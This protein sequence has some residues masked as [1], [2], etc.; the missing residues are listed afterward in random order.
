MASLTSL[1]AFPDKIFLP[2]A[3]KNVNSIQINV[4]FISKC[5]DTKHFRD[6]EFLRL[7]S[8][9]FDDKNIT[10]EN[11]RGTH[12]AVSNMHLRKLEKSTIP[13]QKLFS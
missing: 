5:P 13:Y 9:S 3:N 2:S 7:W 11:K 8:E 4:I 12:N 6:S 10:R 1:E